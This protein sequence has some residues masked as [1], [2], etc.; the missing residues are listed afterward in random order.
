VE[1]VPKNYP[2]ILSYQNKNPLCANVSSIMNNKANSNIKCY[3]EIKKN[4][5]YKNAAAVD[6]F[7]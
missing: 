1:I 2:S 5:N 7:R 4:N 6:L 3:G